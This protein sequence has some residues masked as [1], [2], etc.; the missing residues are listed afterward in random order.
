MLNKLLPEQIANFWPVIKYAVEQS[1]PPIVSD[2]PEKVNRVLTSCL[3]GQAEVWASY[4]RLSE[5]IKFN[6]IAVTRILIDDVSM[7]NNLLL[8]CI[9][10]YTDINNKIFLEGL[11]GLA[12]Y[13]KSKKCSQIIA[14]TEFPQIVALSK[15]LGGET[16]YTFI[17]FDVNKIIQNLDKL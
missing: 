9:Y 16:K 15:H 7:T 2:H 11:K 4:E 14:Y 1:L 5:G 3:M 6:G 12:D 10:G 8:Y 13:A 17:S